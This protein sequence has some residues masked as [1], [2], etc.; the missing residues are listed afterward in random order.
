MIFFTDLIH[1]VL[2][3]IPSNLVEPFRLDNDLQVIVLAVIVGSTVAY[4]LPAFN[5][6]CLQLE[7]LMSAWKDG[8]IKKDGV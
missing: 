7:L 1:L 3:I 2:D 8:C 5:G 4:L 6:F